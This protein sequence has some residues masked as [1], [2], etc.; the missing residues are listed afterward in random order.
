MLKKHFDIG[1][2][3]S[4][5]NMLIFCHSTVHPVNIHII[6]PNDRKTHARCKCCMSGQRGSSIGNAL[7]IHGRD[8][9]IKNITLNYTVLLK[10][11]FYFV[12]QKL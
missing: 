4:P 12:L 10:G 11:N 3:M 8:Q 9:I 7:Y 6:R 1:I 5:K 2:L